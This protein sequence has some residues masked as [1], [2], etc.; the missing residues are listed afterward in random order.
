MR[1]LGVLTLLITL[2]FAIVATS[3]SVEFG[4]EDDADIVRADV[5]AIG[6][7]GAGAIAQV[8]T[9]HKGGPFHD[10]A[11]FAA[12]TQPGQV[13]DRTRL[14]VASTSNFGAPVARPA[15]APGSIVSIDVSDGL[16]AVPPTFAAGGG[17]ASAVGG[18]VILYAAQSPDF[19]NG[20]KNPAAVTADRPSVSLP[21]G[22]SFNNG[23]GRP[24][25]ANA[26]NG[27]AGEGT[28]TVI[29]PQ[30]FP[31]AGAPDATAGGVFAGSLTNRTPDSKGGLISAAVATALATKSPDLGIRAV[32][33]AALADGSIV[34]VHVQNGVDPLV[35][36]GS[37]TPISGISTEAAES[38][39][40][41]VVTRVGM[42]F[43]WVPTR[44]LY[45]TDPLAN[46]ILALDINNEDTTVQT[47]FTA[48]NARYL[49]ARHLNEPIDIAPAMPEVG[50]RNFASNT[51]LGGGSDFYVLNRGT[52]SIV[53]IRQDG[54]EIATRKIHAEVPGFR[55]QGLAVSEDARVI[56]VTATA[57]GRQGVVL[58]M[59][60]F[61]AG[62]VTSSL[63]DHAE[64]GG[65]NGAVAQGADIFNNQLQP[66]QGL[67]PLFNGRA[68][69]D[70]H[71]TVVANNRLVPFPGGM[72]V[73][74][75]SFVFRVAHIEN[76]IFDPLLGRG[77]PIARQH[78]IAELG[79]P[80]RLPTGIPPQATAVSK[81]SAMTLRGTSLLDNIRVTHLEQVRL[82]Q[83]A[84]LRGRLNRL[85]DGRVGRF[86]WKAQ[87]ATLV[88]FMG[89]AFRDEIGLTNP[90]AP[91]DLVNGCGAS[92]LHPE[93]DAVPLT[94]LV[95]F[96]NTL[97]PAVPADACL[98]SP[99]AA[100]FAE[101]AGGGIGCAT[102]HRPTM[103]GP[104]SSGSNPTTIRPY[105]D[106]LLH[107]MGPGLADGFLQ[108]SATGSE[109]RTAPLWRLSDRQQFLH[110]GR[111][112]SIGEAIQA[113]GGQA[114]GA[115]DRFRALGSSDR[116]ALLAFL[117]CI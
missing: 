114:A 9:F 61:G 62:P 31:L 3:R 6:I 108:G 106:L 117:S 24:W 2:P 19:L 113:H 12:F 65:Q 64:D 47:L 42:V 25:F 53:R 32:F 37:F 79:I 95:A 74:P 81:R 13:L 46:R 72:G 69:N 116:Q 28:I 77:G 90:L 57:P 83:P 99:G 40:P 105:T 51:T 41:R 84:D 1:K 94:S 87:T 43:N 98:A 111:A 16:V 48:T 50:A 82:S 34:Q 104:G 96:L 93:A 91:R 8:G 14:F 58:R 60:A 101:Q 85:A 11:D 5:V 103:F 35:P 55:V 110:D 71:N 92:T 78:S 63:V 20:L 44:I 102:C 7:P 109:F 88:E 4:S 89:E 70:C 22:I 54:K 68:C 97:D 100:I 21:L 30:G 86:G 45:V 10:R 15:E 66:D 33:F 18:K 76:G 73:S 115:V 38:S 26:P 107:D 56:W 112:N 23:F 49:R 39:N 75:G 67:G 36:P 80:C 17:Q 59:P 27:S 29:D 52:N